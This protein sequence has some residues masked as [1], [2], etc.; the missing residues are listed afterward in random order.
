MYQRTKKQALNIFYEKTQGGTCQEGLK[1][2][3]SRSLIS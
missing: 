1:W 2:P 3:I